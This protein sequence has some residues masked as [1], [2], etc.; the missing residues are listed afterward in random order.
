MR[1]GARPRRGLWEARGGAGWVRGERPA[2]PL[3]SVQARARQVGA[4]GPQSIQV[5]SLQARDLGGG[6]RSQ[7]Q[8]MGFDVLELLPELQEGGPRGGVQVPA[9]LHDLVDR[10]RA[11][12][13]GIHL[14]A[15]LHPRDDVLQGLWAGGWCKS[16][17]GLTPKRTPTQLRG[18]PSDL[19]LRAWPRRSPGRSQGQACGF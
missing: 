13:R 1:K 3:G 7:V 16:T 4:P 12:V 17:R 9:A 5:Q 19:S 14:V 8:L 2:S 11:A 15:L 18:S 6:W 10:G